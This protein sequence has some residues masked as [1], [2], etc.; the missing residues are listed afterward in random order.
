MQKR[1]GEWSTDTFGGGTP[2]AQL[3]HLKR[4]VE[5]LIEAEKEGIPTDM[6]AADVLLLLLGYAHEKDIDLFDVTRTKHIWNQK[7]AWGP[8]DEDGVQEHLE[9]GD[10]C[11]QEQC[12]RILQG[13]HL[14][15]PGCHRWYGE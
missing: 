5:E 9:E 12:S 3:E 7:R 14:Y 6:E 2:E 15:C 1:V 4:E 11:P 8:V 10:E 13:E